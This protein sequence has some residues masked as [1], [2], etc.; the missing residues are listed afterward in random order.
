MA[1]TAP[2]YA[3]GVAM[4]RTAGYVVFKTAFLAGTEA[5]QLAFADRLAE[6]ARLLRKAILNKT[7]VSQADAVH[8][9]APNNGTVTPDKL[10]DEWVGTTSDFGPIILA[11]RDCFKAANNDI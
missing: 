2:I 7:V 3:N 4:D 11:A 8:K 10:V 5:E 1:I 6:R 9:A